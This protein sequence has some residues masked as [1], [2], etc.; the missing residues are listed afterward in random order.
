MLHAAVIE[1]GLVGGGGVYVAGDAVLPVKG[2]VVAAAA[3][4]T[5]EAVTIVLVGC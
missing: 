5:L 4:G 1:D 3:A 2:A